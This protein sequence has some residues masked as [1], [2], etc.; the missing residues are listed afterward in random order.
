MPELRER[1]QK[2]LSGSFKLGRELLGGGMSRVFVAED[3]SLGRT[4]VVKVL[5]PD[6]AAGLN[7][8]RFK[9]EIMLAAQLQHPHIVPVLAAGVADDLP[10]FVMPFVVGESLR[11]RITENGLSV[12][13]TV[14]VLRDVARALSF[15]HEQG[16][17]H[18]DIKPDNVLLAGGSA[19]VTDF[20][21]AKAISSA[22][23]EPPGE[24]L[25]QVGTSLG[26]PTYMSPEQ[27]AGDPNADARSDFY[28]FGVMAYELLAGRPPFFDRPSHALIMAH[29]AELPEPIDRLVPSIPPVLADVVMR[30]LAKNPKDRPQ[31]AQEILEALDDVRTSGPR[32]TAP[33]RRAQDGTVLIESAVAPADRPKRK[34]FAVIAAAAVVVL[35]AAALLGKQFFDSSSAAAVDPHSVAVVPFRVASADPSH[36]YLREGMVDLIAAKLS[37]EDLRAVEPRTVLD[38]WKTAGGSETVDLSREATIALAR[39]LRSGRA[40]LGDVV[41]TP[42]R[43]TLTLSLLRV[44]EGNEV[45]RVSIEGAPDSLASLVDRITAQLLARTSGES[46]ARLS[47]LTGTSLPAL[48]AYLDGQARLRRGEAQNAATDFERALKEDSTFAL[49]GLGLRMATS[50]YGDGNLGNRGLQVAL[51]EKARLSQRDQMLLEAVAGPRYPEPSTHVEVLRARERFLNSDHDNAEAWYL[52]GDH[53]FHYG[54][55]MGM[56]DWEERALAGFR[57]AMELDSLYLPGY[58]HALPLAPSLGDSAFTRR[59]FLLRSRADTS[60]LWRREHE[61]YMAVRRGD[62]AGANRAL[63]LKGPARPA[64]PAAIVRLVLFDGTGAPYAKRLVEESV[65]EA[66]TDDQRRGRSRFAYDVMLNLGRPAEALRYLRASSDSGLDV[67]G[68]VLMLRG[69]SVGE[70]ASSS[71]DEAVRLLAALE[72]REPRDST[73]RALQRAAVRA[74]EP[75]RLSRGDTSLTRASLQRMRALMPTIPRT[76]TLHF[77]I[78]IAF[79]EM[80]HAEATGS[81]GLRAAAVRLDSL[82]QLQDFAVTHAGRAGHQALA[83]GRVFEK[84]GDHRRAYTA[85]GRVAMWGNLSMPYLAQQIREKARLAARVGDTKH[86]VRAYHHFLG[87]RAISEPLMKPQV[88]SARRELAALEAGR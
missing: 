18:R 66:A 72:A 79:I 52:L 42:N 88:D 56:A 75:W 31:S 25:T 28:S 3:A 9:R 29:I 4:V 61:W 51:R 41:G 49:A 65:A 6:L 19:V 16:V 73:G 58:T 76:D 70:G 83:L 69:A 17:V 60:T 78:E 71:I 24:V 35:A 63:D 77:Q 21:I 74:M 67:N 10:Y 57:K 62:T 46:P 59:A 50:W 2:G 48:R 7:A 12:P 26:T 23:V 47:T 55:A 14:S 5:M 85:V 86:A 64:L 20:G 84:L 11:K 82:T 81:P 37:S 39:R 30:C 44:P 38:A 53:V 8:Q 33:H 45:A 68:A 54:A 32:V 13:E 22:A 15:A 1:L 40:L 87:L 43:L 36:H 27:A 34:K 80:L